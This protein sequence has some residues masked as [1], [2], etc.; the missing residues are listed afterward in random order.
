MNRLFPFSILRGLNH[1][2]DTTESLK[3]I[4]IRELYTKKTGKRFKL[5]KF[6]AV[7]NDPNEYI[8]HNLFGDR[9]IWHP[10]NFNRSSKRTP[11]YFD[12]YNFYK[13][14]G[15]ILTYSVIW[16][17]LGINDITRRIK[18]FNIVETGI[19]H[20]FLE[21]YIKRQLY[22]RGYHLINNMNEITKYSPYNPDDLS[23]VDEI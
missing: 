18:K 20:H 22:Y 21:D 12:D 5:I 15:I 23:W 1:A 10:E 13:E 6:K 4:E 8:E 11:L 7:K 14:P 3:V 2:W 16:E 17:A 19:T 9:I